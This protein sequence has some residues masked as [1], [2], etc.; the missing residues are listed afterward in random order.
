M[1]IHEKME[2]LR[3]QL[4]KLDRV[5]VAFSGGVDSTF[6]L[7]AAYETLGD[8]TMAVI[9]RAATLPQW[10]YKE[11]V[12]F[13]RDLGVRYVVLYPDQF[14]IENFV[15]NI[16]DR[17]YDCK[18]ELFTGILEAAEENGMLYVADGSNADD[19]NDYR[20][21]TRAVRE[22][23]IISPLLEAGLYKAEIRQLSREMGLK[24]WDKPS[25]ACLASRIP[26]GQEITREKLAMV[27]AAEKFLLELGFKQFRVRHHGDVARI[28]VA[29]DEKEKFFDALLM[30]RIHGRLTELG[31]KYT[32]LDLKGYRMGSMNEGLLQETGKA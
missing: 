29:A 16:P 32:A 17:C 7:K 6:L 4:R 1:D 11:A 24:T 3:S 30:D 8:G 27:E 10:E 15:K 28:E 2:N 19:V 13:V 22:L 5:A 23:G 12:E 14:S 25:L 21:G 31:F 26:Y 20:P 9:A 18:K